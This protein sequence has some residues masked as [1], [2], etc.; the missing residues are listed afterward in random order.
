MGYNCSVRD[1][2][3]QSDSKKTFARLP[4]EK[5]NMLQSLPSTLAPFFQEYDFERLDL[6]NAASLIIER[7]LQFGNRVELRWL[8]AQYPRTQIIDW[9]RRFGK[10]RLPNPHRAFWKVILEINE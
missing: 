6:H 2:Q 4:R 3:W 5:Q 8:F 1:K 9:V 7:T 10:D